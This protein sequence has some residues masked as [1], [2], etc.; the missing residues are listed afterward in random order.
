MEKGRGKLSSPWTHLL[1]AVLIAPVTGVVVYWLSLYAIATWADSWQPVWL[2][3][4]SYAQIIVFSSD[5]STG[6][7]A[8]MIPVSNAANYAAADPGATFLIPVDRTEQ[9]QEQLKAD[10]KLSWLTFDV[11]P[12][13][14]GQQEITIYFMDRTDDSYGSRYKASKDRVQL[15]S[16]RYA[17]DR[18]AI[19]VLFYAMVLTV[20]IHMLVL[21]FLLLRAIYVWRRQR[22][23]IDVVMAR[24]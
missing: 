24:T 17:A 6:R 22:R 11:K 23:A 2:G 9:I 21:G 15:E 12:L 5:R 4:S 14:D 20:G 16:Y 1:I 3:D 19:G 8:E 7:S 13:A 18:G 10:L